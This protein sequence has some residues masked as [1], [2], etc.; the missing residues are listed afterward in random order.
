MSE[1]PLDPVVD[2]VRSARKSLAQECGHDVRKM[3]DLFRGMQQEH[4]DRVRDP[5]ARIGNPLRASR[6]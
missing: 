1:A 3:L 2:R 4:P 5:R 6:R